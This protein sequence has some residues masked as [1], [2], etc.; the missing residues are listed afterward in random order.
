MCVLYWMST[1][2][3]IKDILAS[4]I[5]ST[6]CVFTGQ[7]FDTVKVRMQVMPGEFSGPMQCFQKTFQG[8]VNKPLPLLYRL[9]L[10]LL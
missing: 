7:P 3:I 9:R 2:D 1:M 10:F 8:H 5:G 4:T 6:A